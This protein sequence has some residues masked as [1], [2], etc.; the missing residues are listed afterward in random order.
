MPYTLRARPDN[1]RVNFKS[2]TYRFTVTPQVNRGTKEKPKWEEEEASKMVFCQFPSE[3][4]EID[5]NKVRARIRCLSQAYGPWAD[6]RYGLQAEYIETPDPNFDGI[7]AEIPMVFQP[8]RQGVSDKRAVEMGAPQ[9]Y[10]YGATHIGE[11][12]IKGDQ[13]R[14]DLGLTADGKRKGV[15]QVANGI[16]IRQGLQNCYVERAIPGF[17]PRRFPD[18]ERACSDDPKVNTL[19]GKPVIWRWERVITDAEKLQE[20]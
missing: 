8:A 10:L 12:P 3:V 18:I 4:E 19:L 14:G 13:M 20:A 11:I 1:P 2:K 15:W 6:I 7:G 17:D 16:V 5:G 9:K